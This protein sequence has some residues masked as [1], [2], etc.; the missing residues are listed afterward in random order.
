M[1]CFRKLYK[2]VKDKTKVHLMTRKRTDDNQTEIVKALRST[3]AT[4]AITSMVGTGFPDLVV[5]YRDVNFLFEV[6]DGSK[7]PSRRKLT[8]AEQ[9]F[10]FAWEGSVEIVTS[11]DD[12][13]AI[14]KG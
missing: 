8:K 10:F 11:V 6:K 9:D 5:G 4:V 2:T 14:L 7:P 13:L 1:Y 12:A 3:G